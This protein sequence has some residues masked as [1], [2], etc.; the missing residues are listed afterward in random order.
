MKPLVRVRMPKV[1]ALGNPVVVGNLM[2]VLL[3][4]SRVRLVRS[5]PVIRLVNLRIF[6]RFVFDIVRQASIIRW[7]SLVLLRSGPRMGT[8]VTAA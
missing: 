5:F 3:Q 6:V 2:V 7:P 1:T 4:A 8:V